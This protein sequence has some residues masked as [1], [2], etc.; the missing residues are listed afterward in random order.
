[1]KFEKIYNKKVPTS[2]DELGQSFFEKV[3]LES[4]EVVFI[5]FTAP[6]DEVAFRI[7]KKNKNYSQ[8][9]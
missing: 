2:I 5:P 8:K 6:G 7:T 4:R 1:M 9:F 3:K